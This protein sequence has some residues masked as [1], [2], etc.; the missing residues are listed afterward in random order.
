MYLDIGN[1]K[2]RQKIVNLTPVWSVARWDGLILFGNNWCA[3]VL[4]L[5][6]RAK[7]H[8]NVTLLLLCS[9]FGNVFQINKFIIRPRLC[10]Y[11]NPNLVYRFL[12]WLLLF[13]FISFVLTSLNSGFMS[14][15]FRASSTSR[16]PCLVLRLCL[17]KFQP[18]LIQIN[19]ID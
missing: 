6:K 12:F 19:L 7:W 17:P 8:L 10:F 3:F 11:L 14:I 5:I 9:L 2:N 13:R 18:H 16:S 4:E 1:V 15:L